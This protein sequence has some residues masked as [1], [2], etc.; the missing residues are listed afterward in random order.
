MT[1]IERLEAFHREDP[2]NPTL[3]RELVDALLESGCFQRATEVLSGLPA[4]AQAEPRVRLRQARCALLT[5]ELPQAAELLQGL[6]HTEVDGPALR[7][8]LAFVQ[9]SM[10]RVEAALR[11]LE[12]VLNEANA[13]AAVHVL[14][15]RLLHWRGDYAGGLRAVERAIAL[16]P[17]NAEAQGVRALLLLDLGAREVARDAAQACMALDDSQAE[18]GSVIGMLALWD[19]RPNEAEAAFTK[20]L[21][22]QP[23]AARALLGLGQVQMLRGDLGSAC[24][25]LQRAVTRMPGHIGSWHA[26]AWCQLLRGDLGA[27]QAS[28]ER[29]LALDRSFGETH[30]GFAILHALRGEVTAAEAEIKRARKLD[31]KGRSAIYARALLRLAQGRDDEARRLIAPL[32]AATGASADDPLAFLKRLRAQMLGQ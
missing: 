12:P 16:A 11:T 26:L 7:H 6:E 23:Q 5:N 28:Y 30:G 8:D 22:R 20:V 32:L 19:Q 24:D 3:A 10:G 13:P 15:A 14:H 25:T 27:A 18:A 2:D 1:R 4:H 31:P 17:D 9:L 21:A 29:A